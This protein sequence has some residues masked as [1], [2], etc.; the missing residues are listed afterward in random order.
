M[1]YWWFNIILL[2]DKLAFRKWRWFVNTSHPNEINNMCLKT[3]Q[4]WDNPNFTT[5]LPFAFIK[6]CFKNK[7]KLCVSIYA[8][9]GVVVNGRDEFF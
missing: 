8:T 9:H 6:A 1:N 3:L 4:L 5:Y 7:I 2:V